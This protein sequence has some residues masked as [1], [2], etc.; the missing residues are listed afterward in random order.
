[1][2]E[3]ELEMMRLAMVSSLSLVDIGFYSLSYTRWG[4]KPRGFNIRWRLV[5]EL[6]NSLPSFY[7]SFLFLKISFSLFEKK[8]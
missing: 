7:F 3:T 5:W 1:V 6:K 8:N 4:L 2:S